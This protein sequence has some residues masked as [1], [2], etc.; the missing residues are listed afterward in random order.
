MKFIPIKKWQWFVIGGGY[1][2]TMGSYYLKSYLYPGEPSAVFQ[3]T[4][5]IGHVFKVRFFTAF[6][7]KMF[8]IFWGSML[9][10]SLI[11]WIRYRRL[12]K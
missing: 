3:E 7:E 12:N 6:T 9:I 10:V 8:A 5:P 11:R 1:V 2:I 4:F